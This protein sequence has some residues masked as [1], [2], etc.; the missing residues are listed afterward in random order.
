MSYK[1][2]VK[3]F[4]TGM[5]FG[6]DF[7]PGTLE[8]LYRRVTETKYD[9]ARTL[10]YYSMRRILDDKTNDIAHFAGIA[11]SGALIASA[12]FIPWF[13]TA[14]ADSAYNAAKFGKLSLKGKGGQGPGKLETLAAEDAT[15][16]GFT[17]EERAKTA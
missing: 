2:K 16:K 13:F 3:A 5:A 11:V 9:P 14:I 15:S 6:F 7:V 10:G 4:A 17:L 12:I 1:T 8:D